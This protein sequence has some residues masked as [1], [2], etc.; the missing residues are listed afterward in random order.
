M[1]SYVPFFFPAVHCFANSFLY[2][3]QYLSLILVCLTLCNLSVTHLSVVESFHFEPNDTAEFHWLQY[4]INYDKQGD[5]REIER[6]RSWKKKKK[7]RSDSGVHRDFIISYEAKGLLQNLFPH[8]KVMDGIDIRHKLIVQSFAKAVDALRPHYADIEVRVLVLL[9]GSAELFYFCQYFLIPFL[10]W[11]S[12]SS[13]ALPLVS[14]F[15]L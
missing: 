14:Y 15:S 12:L 9:R 6:D 11:C 10:L 2:S 3:I 7:Q 4:V 13:L 1:R 8:A 5:N